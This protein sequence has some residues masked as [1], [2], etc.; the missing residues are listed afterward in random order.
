MKKN[1]NGEPEFKYFLAED[2]NE[3]KKIW[4]EF[5]KFL[6]DLDNFVIYHYAF[7]ERQIFDRLALR[8]GV[9]AEIENKFKNN[10]IDLHRAVVD[11]VVLPLYFYSLKDVARYVGFQW[12]AEDAGGAE[13]VVWYNQ[14]KET[15][16][17]KILQKILDY[18]KDDVVATM[19]V[20]EWLEKQKP[21]MQREVLPE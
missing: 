1:K 15:G 14:W 12:Q 13:S 3:E 11:S 7:Y 17:K 6:E 5:K 20:K 2:K 8:Y 21:K 4:E 19:V 10:T 16:D 18:N 9:S